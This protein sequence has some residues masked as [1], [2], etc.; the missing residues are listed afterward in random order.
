[1]SLIL[2]VTT[3]DRISQYKFSELSVPFG[4]DSLLNFTWKPEFTHGEFICSGTSWRLN[5]YD[6]R[7]SVGGADSVHRQE[8]SQF[9]LSSGASILCSNYIIKVLF[10]SSPFELTD[11]K[12]DFARACGAQPFIL[13]RLGTCSKK[14]FLPLGKW[15]S[16]GCSMDAHIRLPALALSHHGKA[17]ILLAS[18]SVKFRTQGLSFCIN[19]EYCQGLGQI[20]LRARNYLE[21]SDTGYRVEILL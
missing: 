20:E 3:Q 21:L 16:L 13:C 8:F 2:S 4:V 7:I 11:L 1:M 9:D 14:I 17:W 6:E 12:H 10:N 19:G 18:D 15:I 5:A